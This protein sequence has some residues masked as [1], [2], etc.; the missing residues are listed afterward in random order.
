MPRDTFQP[1]TS[2]HD[3]LIA[4]RWNERKGAFD[5]EVQ[6][7]EQREQVWRIEYDRERGQAKYINQGPANGG[8]IPKYVQSEVLRIFAFGEDQKGWKD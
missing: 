8:R 4:R 7:Q 5:V 2:F 1:I 3:F 6:R